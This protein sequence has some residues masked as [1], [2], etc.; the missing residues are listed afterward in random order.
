MFVRK[1][2]CHSNTDRELTM[3]FGEGNISLMSPLCCNF[4]FTIK[5]SY[6]KFSEREIGR[7]KISYLTYNK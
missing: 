5:K 6:L 1:N 4:I 3:N 7:I 2:Q